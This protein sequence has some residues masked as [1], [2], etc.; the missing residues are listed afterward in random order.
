[1]TQINGNNGINKT[2]VSKHSEK[3]GFSKPSTYGVAQASGKVGN[4]AAGALGRVLAANIPNDAQSRVDRGAIAKLFM[5]VETAGLADDIAKN[6]KEALELYSVISDLDA[7]SDTVV[8]KSNYYNKDVVAEN[9][10][11]TAA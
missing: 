3:Q 11:H 8:A 6:D 2:E 4:P 10:G 7:P 1:M 9:V 5:A